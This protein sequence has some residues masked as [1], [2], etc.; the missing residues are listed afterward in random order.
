MRGIPNLLFTTI[1]VY[2]LWQ[3]GE[4][5]SGLS[6][7]PVPGPVLGM[8][9]FLLGL[10]SGLIRETWVQKAGDLM[11]RHIPFFF[12]APGVAILEHLDLLRG[13]AVAIVALMFF[14]TIVVM[15]VTGLVVQVWIRRREVPREW[16]A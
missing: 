4:W 2:A 6:G 15:G 16:K 5:L 7:L 9:L 13:N 12:I 8:L 10:R 3:L 14:S 1:L 11:I